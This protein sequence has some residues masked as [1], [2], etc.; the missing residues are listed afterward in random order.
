MPFLGQKVINLGYDLPD[1][2]GFAMI[3]TYLSQALQISDLRVSTGGV[4]GPYEDVSDFVVF[5]Q[6]HA[7]RISLSK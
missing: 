6:S 7:E 2:Y 5:N 4:G 1:L 3:G